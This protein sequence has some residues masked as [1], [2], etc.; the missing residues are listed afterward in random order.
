MMQEFP[1]LLWQLQLRKDRQTDA[2]SNILAG[3]FSHLRVDH[4]GTFAILLCDQ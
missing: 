3:T 1:G 4:Q 2:P